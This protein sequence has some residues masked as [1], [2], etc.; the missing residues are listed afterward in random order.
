MVEGG[1]GVTNSRN[2]MRGGESDGFGNRSELS[3]VKNEL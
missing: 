2:S 1:R 3:R